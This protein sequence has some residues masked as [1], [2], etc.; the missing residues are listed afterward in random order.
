MAVCT[1]ICTSGSSWRRSW[2]RSEGGP[3]RVVITGGSGLI[4]SA[5]A[6][7]LGSAGYDAVVLTRNVGKVGPLPPGVRA[8]EWDGLTPKGW[9]ELL[10]EETS[11]V[12]L[13]GEGIA[14]SRWT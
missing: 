1:P 7:H 5:L 12:H 4:G 10:D 9:A 2:R 11:I 8:Q 3:M 13:A 6:R 14:E